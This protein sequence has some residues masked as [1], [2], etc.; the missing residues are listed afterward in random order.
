MSTALWLLALLGVVGAFDTLYFHEWRGQLVARP[1]MRPELRLHV[2]RDAI[3]VIVFATLPLVAWHGWFTAALALLLLAE[4][5]ITLADFVTED[6]VRTAIGGVFPGE[7]I[8]HAIMGIIYGAM[9][10]YLTPTLWQWAQEPTG[11]TGAP[12]QVP[13]T[14]TWGLVL[15]AAGILLHGLRDLYAVLGMP[16][17]NWPWPPAPATSPS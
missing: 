1:D 9:L 8:T 15:M 3:Y 6:R 4:I 17:S 11:I 7:R 12:H 2:A 5:V 14:V 10:A 13:A 16:G